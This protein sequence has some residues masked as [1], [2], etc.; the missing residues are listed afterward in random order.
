MMADIR[1]ASQKA[2]F[3]ELFV[4]RGLVSDIAGLGRLSQLVGRERA[5]ELLFT[6]DVIDAATAHDI[7]LVSRVVEHDQLMPT[8]LG[9]ARR[10]AANPPLAVQQL[11]AGLR[12]A[13]DPDW[14]EL[15]TL[16]QLDARS[17]VHHRRPPRRRQGV[18]REAR[19]RLHR[20][21]MRASP[22]AVAGAGRRSGRHPPAVRG[23]RRVPTGRRGRRRGRG[24]PRARRRTRRSHR[25]AVRHPRPSDVDRSRPG[26]V[27]RACR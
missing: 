15:G 27:P 18:P 20:S 2:K 10:I 7:G 23:R 3:G 19:P 25:A 1:V 8:A 17:A 5:A 13:L 26:V 6:G 24:R 16:G 21:L 4:L 14:H 22:T 9:L 11:K 12:R